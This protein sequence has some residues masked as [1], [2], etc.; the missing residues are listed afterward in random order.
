[1]Q[2]INKLIQQQ[3]LAKEAFEKD[4][5]DNYNVIKDTI[6]VIKEQVTPVINGS[7][8]QYVQ[9]VTIILTNYI[10]NTDLSLYL[11]KISG[12][13]SSLKNLVWHLLSTESIFHVLVVFYQALVQALPALHLKIMP[14]PPSPNLWTSS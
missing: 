5:A 3:T 2:V 12:I 7:V 14:L 1:M 4:I 13:A 8:D 9:G 6:S 10:V 11:V